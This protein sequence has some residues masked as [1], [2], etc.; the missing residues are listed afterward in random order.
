MTDLLEQSP[1]VCYNEVLLDVFV[2]S[3]VSVFC[4]VKLIV[5]CMYFVEH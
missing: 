3:I 4:G 1:E 2:I 5:R